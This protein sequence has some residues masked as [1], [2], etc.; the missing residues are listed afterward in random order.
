MSTR[1]KLAKAR[2][3]LVDNPTPE[4]LKLYEEYKAESSSKKPSLVKL[5]KEER[6][7]IIGNIKQRKEE[8]KPLKDLSDE[9]GFSY[10]SIIYY[11]TDDCSKRKEKYRNKK[12]NN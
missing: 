2:K 11:C 8:G 5:P 9:F 6:E 7:L 1:S 10:N 4:N 3:Q 12:L